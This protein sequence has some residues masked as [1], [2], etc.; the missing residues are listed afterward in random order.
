MTVLTGAAPC[1]CPID[2]GAAEIMSW[3]RTY[4]GRADQA[5]E[6]R[7]LVSCLLTDFPDLDEVVMAAAE[8]FDRRRPALRLPAS[9][10]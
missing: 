8:I 7:R 4:P 1:P 2:A 5:C 9:R 6:L 10:G 3:R